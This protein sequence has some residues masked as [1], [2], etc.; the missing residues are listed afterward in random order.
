MKKKGSLDDARYGREPPGLTQ[1]A[2]Q[3]LVRVTI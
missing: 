1:K 3:G 2:L